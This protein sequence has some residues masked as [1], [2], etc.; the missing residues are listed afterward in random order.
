MSLFTYPKKDPALKGKIGVAQRVHYL[1]Q[2]NE[3]KTW[4]TG[5]CKKWAGAV[6]VVDP[7]IRVTCSW[8]LS[9]LMNKKVPPTVT[10]TKE[11]V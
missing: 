2:V 10:I 7:A 6:V 11:A 8:C 9:M 3:E 4:A 1:D 5:A